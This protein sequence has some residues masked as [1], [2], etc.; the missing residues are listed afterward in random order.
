MQKAVRSLGTAARR[1]GSQRGLG[2]L[3]L[4]I[5]VVVIGF[6]LGGILKGQ[7]LIAGARLKAT[8][9]DI[10]TIRAAAATYRDRYGGFPGDHALAQAQLGTPNGITWRVP[11][12]DGTDQGCDGD[13]IIEGNGRTG[14]TLL[15]WQH[16][17]LA[18]LISGIAV[19]SPVDDSIG[20]GL[21]ST[22]VGGGLAVQH[23]AVGGYATH[24]LRLGT[25]AEL[26]T[27]VATGEQAHGIDS[28]IDDGRPGTGAVRVTTAACIDRGD[29]N[30]AG[31]ECLMYFALDQGRSR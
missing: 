16:L 29:Y 23:Q 9:V 3:E 15:F 5:V 1:G 22:A 8:V 14:E 10:E 26:A 11:R 18:N 24:W 28:E 31:E 7:E 2:V 6:I 4:A 30:P 21:P 12:C 20:A 13:G 17:T 19:A 25:G 27:G